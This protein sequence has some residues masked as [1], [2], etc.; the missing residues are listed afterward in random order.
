ALSGPLVSAAAATNGG[1]SDSVYGDPITDEVN[2][3]NHDPATLANNLRVVNVLVFNGNGLPGPY[4]RIPIPDATESTVAYDAGLFHNRLEALRIPSYWDDYG[5]GT[6]T[7]PYWARDLR[8]SIGP[9][10]AKF[11]HPRPTPARITYMIADARYQVYGW[12]V[13]MHRIAEEFSTL[14]DA[15]AKGFTLAGSGSGSVITPP[16]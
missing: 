5:P 12:R 7:W 16:E 3:E 8:W 2:W 15:G 14:R 13:T 11:A 10:M 9:I 6:H 1:T 4:D